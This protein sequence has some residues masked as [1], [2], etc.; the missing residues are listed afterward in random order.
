MKKFV[1]AILSAAIATVSVTSCGTRIGS[2]DR[3]GSE[4]PGDFTAATRV[5]APEADTPFILSEML[6][7]NSPP[8]ESQV[9]QPKVNQY[10]LYD[11][12]FLD[13]LTNKFNLMLAEKHFVADVN[14]YEEGDDGKWYFWYNERNEIDDGERHQQRK[15][16]PKGESYDYDIYYLQNADAHYTAYRLNWDKF[17]Y[18]AMP[19]V[20]ADYE[21]AA[22]NAAIPSLLFYGI[23]DLETAVYMG[24]STN[25]ENGLTLEQFMMDDVV[26]S[27]TYDANGILK[28]SR[29]GGKRVKVLSFENNCPPLDIPDSFKFVDKNKDND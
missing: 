11:Q 9:D 25:P 24:Y 21:I 6:D 7:S 22:L 15:E 27:F 12:Y 28:D 14:Y 26:Y 20:D 18:S 29:G 10:G 23:D 17:T 16:D 13:S 2:N 5:D 3:E 4:R 1:C 8:T 19:E